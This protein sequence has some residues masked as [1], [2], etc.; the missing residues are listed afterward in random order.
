[1]LEAGRFCT[2][3]GL[4]TANKLFSGTN[5]YFHRLCRAVLQ[6]AQQEAQRAVFVAERVKQERQQKILQAEGEAEA[7]KMISFLTK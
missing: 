1:M 3:N 7:I 6:V 2:W 4:I 5:C